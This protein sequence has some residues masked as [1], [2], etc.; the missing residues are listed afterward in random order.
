MIKPAWDDA[1]FPVIFE[2]ADR[3]TLSGSGL[4]VADQYTIYT[5]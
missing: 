2:T 1:Y 4:S 5:I 3:E